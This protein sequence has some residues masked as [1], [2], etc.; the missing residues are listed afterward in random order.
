MFDPR[1]PRI[2]R[3]VADAECNGTE[4][5]RAA[6]EHAGARPEAKHS[7]GDRRLRIGRWAKRRAKS[8]RIT[9]LLRQDRLKGTWGAAQDRVGFGPAR[10]SGTSHRLGAG[11]RGSENESGCCG[12]GKRQGFAIEGFRHASACRKAKQNYDEKPWL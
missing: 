9:A 6:A 1:P 4:H 3:W 10:H 5:V 7:G 8:H 2:E 11:L 12:R